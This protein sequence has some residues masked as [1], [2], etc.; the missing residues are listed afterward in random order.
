MGTICAKPESNSHFLEMRESQSVP[1]QYRIT[2]E[3]LGEGAFSQVKKAY[4]P[5]NHPVAIK[6]IKLSDMKRDRQL[7]KREVAIMEKT[8]HPS[9]VAYIGFFQ[10]L[11]YCYIVTEL[12]EGDNLMEKV[13]KRGK[14]PETEGAEI[15]KSLLSALRYLHGLGIC[16]RDVKPENVLF[17]REG[18]AKL[19]DFGLARSL[20]DSRDISLV[21]TPYY[22]APEALA[23]QYSAKC[24]L[25]S[26]GVLLYFA[27]IGHLPFQG[28]DWA[29]Q[30]A[31][32]QSGHISDW[33][34]L[35]QSGKLFLLKL[36]QVSPKVRASA[37]EAL[38]DVWLSPSYC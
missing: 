20:V 14:L 18:Y 36:L 1:V 12:C 11:E 4:N 32:V 10:D 16:H 23:G 30:Q 38:G 27:L 25:W 7:I 13:R 17:T 2:E 26:L 37:S 5:Q 29:D 34:S 8:Q 31:K 35:T 19:S 24:D 9:I 6:V 21:G 15:A 3:I 28:T 33:G 22:L